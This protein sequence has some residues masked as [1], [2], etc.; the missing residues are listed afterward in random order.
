[1][2]NTMFTREN[3]MR[4]IERTGLFV[5]RYRLLIDG[6]PQYVNVKAAMVEEQGEK[7]LIVGVNNIDAHV[8]LEQKYAQAA[9]MDGA[10]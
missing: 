6:K 2:F 10:N 5:L 3:V 7:K 1:M 9:N 4:E 8:Q